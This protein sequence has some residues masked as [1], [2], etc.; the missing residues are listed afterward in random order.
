M[1]SKALPIPTSATPSRAASR[2]IWGPATGLILISIVSNLLLLTGPLFMLQIYDR[3]LASKSVPTLAALTALVIGLYGFYALLE[4]V[5][6]RMA[7]RY[8]GLVSSRFSAELFASIIRSNASPKAKRAGDPI[9]DLDTVRQFLAG[10]APLALLDMPWMPIYLLIVFL[11]HPV[12]GW[13]AIGGAAIITVLMIV[14]EWLSQK[15]ADAVN[16]ATNMRQSQLLDARVNAE[17]ISAMGMT[18][19]LTHRWARGAADLLAAQRKAADRAVLFS[20]LTKAFRLLLQSGVLAV[21][22]YLAIAGDISAGLM[23]AASIVTARALA[24]VEQVIANWRGFVSARQAM[25]RIRAIIAEANAAR[26]RMPLPLPT[27]SLV[28]TDLAIAPAP[29]AGPII[30]GVSFVLRA[31]EAMGVLGVSGCGKS[32]LIRTLVGV[33]PALGGTI[34]LDGSEIGHFDPERLGTAIGYLPQMVELFDGTVA[35]NIARFRPDARP[36]QVLEAARLAGIHDLVAGLPQGYDTQIGERGA[37]LSAGQ[38]QRIGLA[39]AL[40]GDP[41]MLVLDEPNSNLD[42]DGDAALNTALAAAKER[43]AIVIIVAH[44]PSAIATA[45]KLLYIHNGRQAAFGAKDD[46]L[47]AITA[48]PA[49]LEEIR[50]RRGR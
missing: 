21:G 31:G 34:R 3:V 25:G 46:V 10:Q 22:A 28:V 49:Q 47:A 14:N 24:P 23:I 16:T 26:P 44:R 1:T 38:R 13:V 40:F 41:F 17:S 30:M 43:G 15:P 4:V 2:G 45:D 39:R 11:F 6:S 50:K 18:G 20:T 33:W 12:L 37:M 36:E 5:R 42:S 29:E 32:S 48:E 9:R 19:T 35:E 7:I 27:K 8:S